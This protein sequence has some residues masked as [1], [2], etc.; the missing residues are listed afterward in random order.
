MKAKSFN[1]ARLADIRATMTALRAEAA[2]LKTVLATEK[3]NMAEARQIAREQKAV[4]AAERRAAAITKAE[5]RLARLRQKSLA[6]VGVKAMR[7][8]RKASKVTVVQA[9]V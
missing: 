7:A 8:N 4:K 6:P 2:A 1:A 5:T 9:S 3:A